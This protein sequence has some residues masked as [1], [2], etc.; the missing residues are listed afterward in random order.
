MKRG[1]LCFVGS[2][3]HVKANSKYMPDYDKNE[4]SNYIIYGDANNLYGCS[5]NKF[6]PFVK[7]EF[8][9]EFDLDK[10]LQ[11]FDNKKGI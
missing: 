9:N 4:E 2:N 1:C 7:R 6:L 5:I 10:I 3:R 11:T 8:V